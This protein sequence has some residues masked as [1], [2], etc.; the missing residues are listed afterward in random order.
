[1]SLEYKTIVVSPSGLRVKGDDHSNEL[2]EILTKSMS[3]LAKEGW[4]V[5]S[6]IPSMTSQGAVVKMLITAERNLEETS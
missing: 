1:M 6:L 3:E 2:A 5:I 4:R